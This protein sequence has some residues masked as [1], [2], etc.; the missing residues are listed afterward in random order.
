MW[1]CPEVRF[2]VTV[3]V[4]P[5]CVYRQEVLRTAGLV[6]SGDSQSIRRKSLSS[7]K[8]GKLS[9]LSGGCT[10]RAASMSAEYR[11]RKV[12]A[13]STIRSDHQAKASRW[14]AGARESQK[15]RSERL[16]VKERREIR[17]RLFPHRACG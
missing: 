14:R 11:H 5:S 10:S 2:Y 13:W 3:F 15:K 12:S 8:S 1:F 4:R 6:V 16:R 17:Q 7:W 9:Q